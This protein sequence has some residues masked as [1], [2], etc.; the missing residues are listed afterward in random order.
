MKRIFKIDKKKQNILMCVYI[1]IFIGFITLL[2]FVSDILTHEVFIV[3]VSSNS[4][5]MIYQFS[6]SIR[7]YKNYVEIDSTGIK[8]EDRGRKYEYSWDRIRR[9]EYKGIKFIPIV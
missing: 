3:F 5:V 8:I 7:E 1:I 9:L 4:A 6:L 2:Y